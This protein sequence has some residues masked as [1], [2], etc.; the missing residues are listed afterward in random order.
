MKNLTSLP[1]TF[2]ISAI[3]L[4]DQ[5]NFMLAK[6]SIGL[7]LLSLILIA[8]LY[9]RLI[10][11]SK[12]I[13][14]LNANAQL[15]ELERQRIS[16]EIHDEVG[17]GLTA[18]KLF[19]EL[20]TEKRQDIS[21]LSQL[22]LMIKAISEKI[23][24]IIWTTNSEKNSLEQ[25]I[26]HIEEQLTQL[27]QHSNIKLTSNIPIFIQKHEISSDFKKECYLL[28][29]EIAH[30]ALKHAKATEVTLLVSFENDCMTIS[31][32]DNGIGF[33]EKLIKKTGMGLDNLRM[34]A[35]RINGDLLIENHNGTRVTLTIPLG[36]L[37][38]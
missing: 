26:Y 35:K 7:L 32:S 6:I 25:L 15:V 17:S 4:D 24:D 36:N 27:L 10:I 13:V 1:S 30:N 37:K 29:K 34:R 16:S 23:N 38:D 22:N 12:Q 11:A 3:K 9:K 18:I 21:E 2:H 31:F 33:D 14:Q 20:I 5:S 19:A 8:F 28:L